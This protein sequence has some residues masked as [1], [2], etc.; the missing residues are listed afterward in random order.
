MNHLC[1]LFAHMGIICDGL[2]DQPSE[3][4]NRFQTH[5]A[6]HR[7]SYGTVEEYAFRLQVFAEAD[8]KIAEINSNPNNTFVSG[9]NFFSTLTEYERK[10]WFGKKQEVS[11]TKKYVELDAVTADSEDWR[12]KGAVNPIQ[13]QGQCGSCWAFSA[14]ASIEGAHFL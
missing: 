8:K 14:T 6:E 12:L 13:N 10:K 4:E 5:L 11:K 9:H 1:S 3:L 7:I 2:K